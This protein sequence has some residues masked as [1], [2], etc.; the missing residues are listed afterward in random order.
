MGESR[1]LTGALKSAAAFILWAG[2]SYI[3]YSPADYPVRLAVRAFGH[4]V[5]AQST[6][7]Y[8][9]GEGVYEQRFKL[10]SGV[11][12]ADKT[13]ESAMRAPRGNRLMA[14]GRDDAATYRSDSGY[15]FGLFDR[16]VTIL[17]AFLA[18][19]FGLPGFLG[20]VPVRVRP[21]APRVP[22]W[23]LKAAD[24]AFGAWIVLGAFNY[25]TAQSC[26]TVAAWSALRWA[27]RAG[28]IELIGIAGPGLEPPKLAFP[29]TEQSSLRRAPDAVKRPSK[30]LAVRTP[31]GWSRIPGG[32]AA[33]GGLILALLSM[34]NSFI[35]VPVPGYRPWGLSLEA[36]YALGWALVVF[37]VG[38]KTWEFLG[39]WRRSEEG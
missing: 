36:W 2:L 20:A 29:G 27:R 34:R 31:D 13:S 14:L 1:P 33:I 4:S 26:V 15:P 18:L 6:G 17:L 23:V 32:T 37:A 8:R 28:F 24:I 12:V 22:A 39:A 25:S 38:Y 5:D 10:A 16:F 3:G 9:V 21:G 19:R 7:S 35:R 11:V 30:F